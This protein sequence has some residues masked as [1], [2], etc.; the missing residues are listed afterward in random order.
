MHCCSILVHIPHTHYYYIHHPVT[1]SPTAANSS[2]PP[3]PLPILSTSTPSPPGRSTAAHPLQTAPRCVCFKC[4]Q[5]LSS[6]PHA[7]HRPHWTP[8]NSC[9]PHSISYSSLIAW[10]LCRPT[11]AWAT[12]SLAVTALVSDAFF[13]SENNL[14]WHMLLAFLDVASVLACLRPVRRGH[15]HAL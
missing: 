4:A 11:P 9:E 13:T 3:P 15:H 1:P 5:P 10:P 6:H 14:S 12:Q 8:V 2:V 7:V